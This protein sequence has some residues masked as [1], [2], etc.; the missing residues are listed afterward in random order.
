MVNGSVNA[1]LQSRTV[2]SVHGR[3]FSVLDMLTGAIVPFAYLLVG[4]LADL[5]FEPL[6]L[7]NGGLASTVGLV[8]GTGRGRGMALMFFLA[9]CLLLGLTVWGLRHPLFAI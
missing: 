4:P 9:G 1:L 7:N 6:L 2:T 3:L 5:V 8:L